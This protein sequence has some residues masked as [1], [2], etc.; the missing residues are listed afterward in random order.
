MWPGQRLGIRLGDR[1]PAFRPP[2]GSNWRGDVFGFAHY[3]SY[4]AQG[5]ATY[6]CDIWIVPL[7]PATAACIVVMLFWLRK[8]Y[9]RKSGTNICPTCG[10][11]LR[12]S[13]NRCPECGTAIGGRG[14]AE[15]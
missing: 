3:R 13:Q 7:W 11:D 15:G 10:Y 4:R 6:G 5:P 12:A 9:L 8:H 14:N 1:G 2:P